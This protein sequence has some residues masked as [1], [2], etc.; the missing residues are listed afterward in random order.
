MTTNLSGQQF[1]ESLKLSSE[2]AAVEIRYYEFGIPGTSSRCTLG[3]G[4]D[5][6]CFV[7]AVMH[8][9]G[10]DGAFVKAGL[11]NVMVGHHKGHLYVPSDWLI[12]QLA[13]DQLARSKRFVISCMVEALRSVS[14]ASRC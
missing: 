5:A 1:E 7:P 9:Q 2:L 11:D 12:Q 6:T 3:L 10:S 4:S 8:P 13:G 14:Q